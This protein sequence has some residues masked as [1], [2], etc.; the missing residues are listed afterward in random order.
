[1][2]DMCPISY[3]ILSPPIVYCREKHSTEITVL[4]RSMDEDQLENE[5]STN[6]KASGL[7]ISNRVIIQLYELELEYYERPK[8]GIKKWKYEANHEILSSVLLPIFN[9]MTKSKAR[10]TIK[11]GFRGFQP[12]FSILKVWW[13]LKKK[14]KYKGDH[15]SVIEDTAYQS[16]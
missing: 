11:I 4:D 1:M 14:L 16:M 12:N 10:F 3:N 7:L 6:D 13:L 15:T 8:F 5:Y 2:K 9:K